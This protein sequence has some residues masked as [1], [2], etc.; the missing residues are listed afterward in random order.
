MLSFHEPSFFA[1][2]EKALK[3]DF[4]LSDSSPFF[5]GRSGAY[6]VNPAELV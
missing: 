4:V 1:V 5:S 2:P 6:I 3:E